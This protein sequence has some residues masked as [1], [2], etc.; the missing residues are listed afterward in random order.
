MAV[1]CK[2]EQCIHQFDIICSDQGCCF[3]SV[4]VPLKKSS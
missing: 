3:V 1:V 4:L 2:M